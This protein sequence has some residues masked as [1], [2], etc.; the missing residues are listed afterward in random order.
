[1]YSYSG[2]TV[3]V[4]SFRA[5]VFYFLSKTRKKVIFKDLISEQLEE[6][7]QTIIIIYKGKKFRRVKFQEVMEL[8]LLIY[9]KFIYPQKFVII[10]YGI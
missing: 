9:Q 4:E 6:L 1:M 3:E 8:N 5:I 2:E 7:R 10:Q